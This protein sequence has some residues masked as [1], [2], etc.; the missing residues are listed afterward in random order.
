MTRGGNAEIII[1]KN[2]FRPLGDVKSFFVGSG[3]LFE[4]SLV[5]AKGFL[6]SCASMMDGPSGSLI[7]DP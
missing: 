6:E 3:S 2:N 4:S 7:F 5:G 1:F